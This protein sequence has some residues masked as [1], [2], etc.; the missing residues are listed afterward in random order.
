MK[1]KGL[2]DE[3][4]VNYKFPSMFIATST[5]SFKCEMES[6]ESC[7]Q[8][9]S[10]AKQKTHVV[11]DDIIVQRYI[12]NPIT[13]AIVFGGLEP[14]DQWGELYNIISAFRLG[15]GCADDIV[16][17]TGYNY[18]EIEGECMMLMQFPNIYVK[19]GRFIPGQK[20]HYDP[21]LGVMLASDNQY[22]M[23][24]S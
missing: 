18:D 11:D 13:K 24:L 19:F 16:I 14:F 20:T 9:G 21:V 4:F 8:N 3:D 1:I 5:C 15:Y 22:G 23:R 2:D 12:Q 10:L 17:Y 7:C 6:G